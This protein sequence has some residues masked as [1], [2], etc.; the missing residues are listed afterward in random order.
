MTTPGQHKLVKKLLESNCTEEELATIFQ[1]VKTLPAAEADKVMDELWRQAKRYPGLQPA[2]SEKMYA[3]I[4]SR[5]TEGAVQKATSKAKILPLPLKRKQMIQF[6]NVA[7]VVILLSSVITWLWLEN[8]GETTITTAFAEQQTITLPDGTAVKLNANSSLRFAESWNQKERRIVW[9]EGEAFFEVAKKTK[10]GQKFQVI[11]PD[12][13]V[14]VLGTVFNVNSRQEKTTV[15]LEEGKVALSLK[16]QPAIKKTMEPGEL[17]T[18]SAQKKKVLANIRETHPNLHTSW[19]DGSLTFE[20][21]P[22]G[23]ILQKIEHIYG[24]QFQV[25]DPANYQRKIT[26]GLPMEK[27][28]I[29]IPML[30]QAMGLKIEKEKD[31]YILK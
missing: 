23:D 16:H 1:M 7:A 4:L 22:L 25:E 31:L 2:F 18:Y 15:Y 13:T 27:L 29:V 26:T 20:K 11:T 3:N 24:I 30:E 9:L 6:I 5:I 8:H 19:K 17:L 14:E 21:T 28:E 12:L 10:T